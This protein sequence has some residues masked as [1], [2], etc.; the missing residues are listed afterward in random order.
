MFGQILV[1]LLIFYCLPIFVH[2]TD[3]NQKIEKAQKE[4]LSKFLETNKTDEKTKI[5]I[6]SEGSEHAKNNEKATI[7]EAE[8]LKSSKSAILGSGYVDLEFAGSDDELS[9]EEILWQPKQEKPE[10]EK[11]SS[12]QSI[13][14][15]ENLNSEPKH[16][17]MGAYVGPEYKMWETGLVDW[18]SVEAKKNKAN[19]KHPEENNGNNE[20]VNKNVN[21]E[22]ASHITIYRTHKPKYSHSPPEYSAHTSEYSSRR[23]EQAN[24]REGNQIPLYGGVRP[25]HVNPVPMVYNW[26][27][28]RG[29]HPGL[30]RQAR[31]GPILLRRNSEFEVFHARSAPVYPAGWDTCAV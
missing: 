22:Y 15:P 16:T 24:R 17:N 21:P 27:Q 31:S 12:N 4:N 7:T 18:K 5:T 14:K 8:H 29:V 20:G 3:T 23:P 1:F 19:G 13:G 28:M 25:R 11:R 2:P 10:P 26:H 30:F 9:S 6:F